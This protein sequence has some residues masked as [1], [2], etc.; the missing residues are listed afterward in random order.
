MKRAVITMTIVSLGLVLA[1]CQEPAPRHTYAGVSLAGG[2]EYDL[3]LTFERRGDRLTG[4]YTVDAAHGAF[5]GAL[6][7]ATITAD[8]TPSPTCTYGF[9]GVLT[10]PTLTGEF[11]PTACP[12]GEGGTWVLERQ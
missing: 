3:T 11:E 7:G 9:E 8:L 1:A 5:R 10:D 12:G 4:E 2:V 6:D